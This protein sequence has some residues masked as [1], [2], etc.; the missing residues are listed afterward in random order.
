[1]KRRDFIQVAGGST[2]ILSSPALSSLNGSK[3]PEQSSKQKIFIYGGD[4]NVKFTNYLASLTRKNNPKICFLAT[5]MG[6]SSEYITRWLQDCT[7][8]QIQPFVQ[9]MF[10]SSKH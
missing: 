10:I 4:F 1:M 5:G 8:L 6:D 9:P 7:G 3:S 2:L